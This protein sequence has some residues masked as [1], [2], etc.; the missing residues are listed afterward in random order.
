MKKLVFAFVCTFAVVGFVMADE[1]GAVITKIDGNKVTYYKT[2]KGGGKGGKGAKKTGDAITS[3][4]SAKL[5]VVKGK[6][7]P[8]TKKFG[9][10]DDIEGGL[11]NEAFSKIDPDTGV[12]VTITTADD[13]ADKG[14]ITQI[15][16]AGFG[17]KMGKM[18]KM[19]KA[20]K[21]GG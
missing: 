21:N 19:G 2:E 18:G 13:G 4:V 12:T 17:G 6:F 16:Q 9:P 5:K 1:F 20:G 7:D 15:M 3:D 11:K 8:D 14:K 10:G